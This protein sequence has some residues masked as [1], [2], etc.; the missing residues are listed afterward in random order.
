MPEISVVISVF[1]EAGS[2]S[3]LWE[4]IKTVSADNDLDVEVIFIDDG[5]S[6]DTGS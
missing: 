5:S 1:N 4:E 6:D 3:T 2:L